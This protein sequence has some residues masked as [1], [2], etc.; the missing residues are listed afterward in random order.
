MTTGAERA[1]PPSPDIYRESLSARVH[2]RQADFREPCRIFVLVDRD[3]AA[4]PVGQ[5]RGMSRGLDIQHAPDHDGMG[6]PLDDI[7]DLA[8]DRRQRAD[9][10]RHAGDARVPLRAGKTVR[11]FQAALAGEAF[12][13][14]KLVGGEDVDAEEA[15]TLQDRPGRRL[16]VDADDQGRRLDRQRRTPTSPSS[17]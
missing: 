16:P 3:I 15:L 10:Q 17:P 11:T 13:D 5:R 6:V 1:E 2:Q 14:F 4:L 12:G 9:Q 7:L 8:I